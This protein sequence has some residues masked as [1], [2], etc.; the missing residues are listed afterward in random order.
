MKEPNEILQSIINNTLLTEEERD[1]NENDKALISE[2]VTKKQLYRTLLNKK[3][4][5][6]EDNNK[7]EILSCTNNNTLFNMA[8]EL[9][10]FLNPEEVYDS[11]IFTTIS[12]QYVFNATQ[13]I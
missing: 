9:I 2:K 4:W 13:L 6:D 3:Y 5:V 7:I 8:K 10:M 12:K 1:F 11:L